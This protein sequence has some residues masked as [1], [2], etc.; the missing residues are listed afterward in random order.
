[1]QPYNTPNQYSGDN[2]TASGDGFQMAF[3]DELRAQENGSKL[4]LTHLKHISGYPAG[5]KMTPEFTLIKDNG[6]FYI[7]SKWISEDVVTKPAAL[8]Y[9]ID[10]ADL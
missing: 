7:K 8:G 9:S 3:A 2:I 10:K 5:Q 6:K 1:M 4:I